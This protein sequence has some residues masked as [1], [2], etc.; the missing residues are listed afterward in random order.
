MDVSAPTPTDTVLMA[1]TDLLP[2]MARLVFT[3]DDRIYLSDDA[4]LY[5]VSKDL[6]DMCEVHNKAGNRTDGEFIYY[7][8]P[9][10]NKAFDTAYSLYSIHR[11]NLDGTGDTDLGTVTPPDWVLTEKYIY[12]LDYDSI[13]V[14]K[15]RTSYYP[16]SE[17]T[18]ACSKLYRMKHDGS[19]KELVYTF[20][21]EEAGTRFHAWTVAGN[22][23]YG[24]YSSFNDRNGDGT[25]TDDE[26]Y[27][28]SYSMYDPRNLIRIDLTTKEAWYIYDIG[29]E[30]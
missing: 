22:Y 7:S 2:A 5:S 17:V 24:T 20:A 21:G 8:S 6:T 29:D 18:L 27:G 14:A 16:G 1:D 13:V 15:N 25:I 19:G 3:L 4:I 26:V 11:M 9:L 10:D 23:V 12:Y 30:H 28:S